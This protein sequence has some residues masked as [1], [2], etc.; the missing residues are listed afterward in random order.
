[1]HSISINLASRP[2][3]DVVYDNFIPRLPCQNHTLRRA[4]SSMG[5]I[6]DLNHPLDIIHTIHRL[7]L[8]LHP[9]YV[10][11]K[12][13]LLK[14]GEC[15]RYPVG[16]VSATESDGARG[17]ARKHMKQTEVESCA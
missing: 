6:D 17:R 3:I 13:R 1:M 9:P 11:G 4:E 7:R 2:W 16:T 10:D 5:A 15:I 12:S 8:E 14:R